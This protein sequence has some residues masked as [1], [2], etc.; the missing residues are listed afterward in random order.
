[1]CARFVG[2][3]IERYLS[4]PAFAPTG[5]WHSTAI[6]AWDVCVSAFFPRS[7]CDHV[8]YSENVYAQK[9]TRVRSDVFPEPLGPM[10]RIEGNVVK[11]L[12][13]NTK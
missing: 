4:E 1:L 9:L 10:R 11:P 6:G 7:N 12:A 2:S 5:R 3:L 13:R 8:S